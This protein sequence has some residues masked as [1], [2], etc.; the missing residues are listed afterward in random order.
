MPI[1]T[2]Q[3]LKDYCLRRLGHPVIEINVDDDQVEDRIQDAIDFIHESYDIKIEKYYL[4]DQGYV[5]IDN[6]PGDQYGWIESERGSVHL[7]KST[8]VD[9]IKPFVEEF[10]SQVSSRDFTAIA[11]SFLNRSLPPVI[12]F[13]DYCVADGRGRV[14]F[15]NALDIPVRLYILS[16]MF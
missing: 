13:E 6:L 1:S 15:A 16:R 9:G 10:N 8:N 7:P 11:Q 12:A 4:E 2:R 5:A 3:Q 14:N